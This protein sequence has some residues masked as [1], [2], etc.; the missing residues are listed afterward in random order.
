[1]INSLYVTNTACVALA[2]VLERTNNST[3][4]RYI[5][6][7]AEGDPD[8][9]LGVPTKACKDISLGQDGDDVKD[10]LDSSYK[11]KRFDL[12]EVINILS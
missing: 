12:L 7:V 2:N 10:S 5:T 11:L 6:S 1:M 9:E 3:V 4:I 8:L